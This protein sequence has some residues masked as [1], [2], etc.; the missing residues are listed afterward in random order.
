MSR[1]ILTSAYRIDGPQRS[2]TLR[3]MPIW[4]WRADRI[5]PLLYIIYSPCQQRS[6]VALEEVEAGYRSEAILVKEKLDKARLYNYQ[7]VMDLRTE[8]IVHAHPSSVT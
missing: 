6:A 8:L 3:E 1:R 7:Q 5:T 2:G 4:R